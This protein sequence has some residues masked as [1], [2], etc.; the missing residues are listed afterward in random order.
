MKAVVVGAGLAGL[1]AARTLADAGCDVTVLDK[2]RAPGGR[3]ATRRIAGARLDH[4]AQFF[5]VRE[6][7]FA[8]LVDAWREAGVVTEWCRGFGEGDGHA[9]YAGVGGMTAIAKHLAAGLDVRC[10]SLVFGLL[11][12]RA[13]D[14]GWHVQLD[15]GEVIDADA[16]VVTCPLPQTSSLLFSAGVSLPEPLGRGDYDRTLALLAVLDRPSGVPDPGGVQAWGPFQFV[17]DHQRKGVSDVPA[18][19]AHADP[20][21]SAAHWHEPADD[22]LDALT[23]LV[24]PLLGDAGIVERQLKRWRFA[25]PQVVWPGRTWVAEGRALAVAG[26]AFGGPRVEGAALS[27]IAAARALLA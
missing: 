21:W 1:L 14:V 15:D 25:T 26:D 16:V 8:A 5:T 24:R 7:E 27:G 12:R 19:T 17:A 23:D 2:G 13:P 4:G 10:E 18:I 22:V 20:A 6:P 9:R 3:L 11:A